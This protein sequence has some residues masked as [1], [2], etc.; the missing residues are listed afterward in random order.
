MKLLQD[1]IV[2]NETIDRTASHWLARGM[3]IES[4]EIGNCALI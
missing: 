1:Y 4:L 3:A 2:Q